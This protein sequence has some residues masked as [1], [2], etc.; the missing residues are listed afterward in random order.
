MDLLLC[1]DF[2]L[3]AQFSQSFQ[4]AGLRPRGAG[5]KVI[6]E[7][8]RDSNL[9]DKY[10]SNLVAALG[11]GFLLGA[12]MMQKSLVTKFHRAPEALLAQTVAMPK[13][14]DNLPAP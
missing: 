13:P 5:V 7:E 12:A 8:R 14:S 11:L 3:G 9:A 2:F 4:S 10:F 1:A 6:A